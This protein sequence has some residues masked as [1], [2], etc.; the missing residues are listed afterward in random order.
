VD[1][2]PLAVLFSTSVE[3]QRDPAG[4]RGRKMNRCLEGRFWLFSRRKV[5]IRTGSSDIEEKTSRNASDP[6]CITC[7]L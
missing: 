6:P 2:V 1:R 7:F 4:R 5:K 3:L